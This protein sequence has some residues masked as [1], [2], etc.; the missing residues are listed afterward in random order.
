[1]CA[2][3]LQMT[4]WNFLYHWKVYCPLV[5]PHHPAKFHQRLSLHQTKSLQ[6]KRS[7]IGSFRMNKIFDLL[8]ANDHNYQD[9]PQL[10]GHSNFFVSQRT[11]CLKLILHQMPQLRKKIHWFWTDCKIDPP[12]WLVWIVPKI[13]LKINIVQF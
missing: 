9:L 3:A 10:K 2:S 8:L 7:S 1:M 4:F 6:G 5:W 11:D 12:I 13:H